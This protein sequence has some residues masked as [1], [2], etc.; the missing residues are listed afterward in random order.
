MSNNRATSRQARYSEYMKE[1]VMEHA[2]R[3]TVL[4]ARVSSPTQARE[5]INS[6]QMQMEAAWEFVDNLGIPRNVV[7]PFWAFGE[8]GL[9][10]K[11]GAKFD[12][13]LRMIDAQEVGLIVVYEHHRMARKVLRAATLFDRC[14]QMGVLFYM[15][16]DLRDPADP[17]DL[18]FLH[19]L[20]CSSEWQVT[21]MRSHNADA[22]FIAA[23]E[24]RFRYRLPAGW[25]WASD[26]DHAFRERMGEA[27]LIDWLDPANLQ[28]YHAKS[29][30]EGRAYYP[31]PFPD[32]DVFHSM[33]LRLQW[34]FETRSVALVRRRIVEGDSWGWPSGRAG[35][36]PETYLTRWHPGD[37]PQWRRARSSALYTWFKN[38]T[39]YGIY[40]YYSLVR[41][42]SDLASR[43]SGR[44]KGVHYGRARQQLRLP[45]AAV[46]DLLGLTTSRVTAASHDN[47]AANA[48]DA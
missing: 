44:R 29:H 6:K 48:H 1:R 46:E 27:G 41:Q 19:M 9:V 14:A 16:G 7:T 4:W 35:L 23:N 3:G 12:D 10:P 20:A 18:F 15:A 5:S 2:L 45:A 24:L 38:P 17:N 26:D 31:L 25:C 33:E 21:S 43:R 36:I 40:S 37:S 42:R 47:P 22:K 28:N 8:S 30:F 11:A 34:L 32:A 13:V 39:H